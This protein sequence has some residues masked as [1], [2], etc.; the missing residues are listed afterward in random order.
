MRRRGFLLALAAGALAS[1]CQAAYRVPVATPIRAALDVS[2]FQR[3]VVA[4]F[5]TNAHDPIDTNVEMV[6]LLGSQFRARSRLGVVA[7]EAAAID[8]QQ[9]DDAIYWRRFGEEHAAPLILTG[10]ASFRSSLETMRLG[11]QIELLRAAG[12][13]PR[14]STSVER[15]RFTLDATLVFIDGGTGA[16]LY[17]HTVREDMLYSGNDKVFALSAYFELMDRTLPGILRLVSDQ[18]FYGTRTLLK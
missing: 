3:V 13:L 15:T 5:V 2:R 9:L 1:G 6:R 17:T 14:A 10:T 18:V 7:T 16:R 11:T 12:Q 4:G 8:R